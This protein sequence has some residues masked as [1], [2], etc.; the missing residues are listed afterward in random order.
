[1]SRMFQ[2]TFSTRLAQACP[3]FIQKTSSSWPGTER[4]FTKVWLW[5]FQGAP[6]DAV[7]RCGNK[8]IV[9]QHA[10]A[11]WNS[12]GRRVQDDGRHGAICCAL[13]VVKFLIQY[14]SVLCVCYINYFECWGCDQLHWH[15]NYRTPRMNFPWPKERK[16]SRTDKMQNLSADSVR[17]SSQSSPNSLKRSTAVAFETSAVL[18]PIGSDGSTAKASLDSDLRQSNSNMLPAVVQQLIATVST[19]DARHI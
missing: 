15:R 1:M 13:T 9:P 10:T 18:N 7:V 16:A 19:A 17:S 6:C 11:L 3:D 14:M 12:A 5:G 2:R 8:P 4:G